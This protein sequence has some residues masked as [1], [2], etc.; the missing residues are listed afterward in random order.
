MAV[1]LAWLGGLNE[2]W[3]HLAVEVEMW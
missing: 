1:Q 2:S 3:M